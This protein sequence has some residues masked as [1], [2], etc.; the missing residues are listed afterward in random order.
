MTKLLNLEIPIELIEKTDIFA[1]LGVYPVYQY[2]NGEKIDNIIAYKYSVVN[3]ESFERY[4]VKVAGAS[5]IIAPELLKSKR[6]L[7]GKEFVRF[8]NCRLK[9]Y[10]SQSGSYEDSI[11]A[12]NVEFAECE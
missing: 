8:S 12:D 9:L 1:L 4:V 2:L 6:D 11:K 10:R 5:P 3:V 7:G